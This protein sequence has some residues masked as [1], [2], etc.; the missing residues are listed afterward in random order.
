M[1]RASNRAGTGVLEDRAEI[2]DVL[3]RYCR[4]MDRVDEQLATSVWHEHATVDYDGVFSGTAADFVTWVTAAHKSLDG[5]VHQ[6]ANVSIELAGDRAVTESYVTV[7]LWT[8]PDAQ[9]EQLEHV[10]RGR[11]LDRWER[12]DARWA[13]GHR[14]FVA[15]L[16]STRQLARRDIGRGGSRDRSDPSY[17]LLAPDRG[18]DDGA[19]ARPSV[20]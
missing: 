19:V 8:R 15:D 1:E 2:F 18:G 17:R 14:E 5:H 16:S 13:I 10:V 9:G 4:A 3:M 6:L 11:Y 7:V 20:R 12:R